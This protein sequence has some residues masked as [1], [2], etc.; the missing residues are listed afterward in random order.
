MKKYHLI[1]CLFAGLLGGIIF[2]LC[3]GAACSGSNSS[4]ST[5]AGSVAELCDRR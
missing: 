3:L 4:T 2:P 5:E 1:V